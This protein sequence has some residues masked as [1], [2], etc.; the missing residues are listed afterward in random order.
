MRPTIAVPPPPRFGDEVEL[1]ST[2]LLDGE[3]V[4]S[5]ATKTAIREVRSSVEVEARRRGIV[6]EDMIKVMTDA[7]QGTLTVTA[8]ATGYYSDA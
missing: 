6:L 5:A 7:Q 1:I 2:V 3:D 8:T 4:Q